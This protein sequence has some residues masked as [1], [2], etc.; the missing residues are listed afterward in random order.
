[1][2]IAGKIRTYLIIAALLPL[3]LIMSVIYFGTVRQLDK[4]RI[5]DA[6]NSLDQYRRLEAA[7]KRELLSGAEVLSQSDFIKESA[8]LLKSGYDKGGRDCF[9]RPQSLLSAPVLT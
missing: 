8:L 2:T 6:S 5:I 4:N 7:L 9:P 3:L 1:M